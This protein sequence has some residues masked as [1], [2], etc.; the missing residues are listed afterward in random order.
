[1]RGDSNKSSIVYYLSI[2]LKDKNS[3]FYFISVNK[4]PPSL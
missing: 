2:K 3:I 4:K 1:M